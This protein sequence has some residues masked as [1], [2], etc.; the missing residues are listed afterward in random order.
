MGTTA[1][2]TEAQ[3]RSRTQRIGTRRPDR[4]QIALSADERRLLTE[5]AR[6]AGAESVAAFIRARTIGQ[7]VTA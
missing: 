4:L 1:E 3:N 7:P 6:E 5:R 2:G